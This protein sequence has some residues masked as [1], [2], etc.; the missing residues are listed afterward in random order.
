MNGGGKLAKKISRKHKTFADEYIA[1]GGNGR[2]AY[3]VAYPHI[4]NKHTASTGANRILKQENVK[5]YIQQKTQNVLDTRRKRSEMMIEQLADYVFR[6]D[7]E[8]Y[9]KQV[10]H[11]TGEITTER[12]TTFQPGIE[13]SIRAADTLGKWLG[14]ENVNNDL[15]RKKME[16][17]IELIQKK[18]DEGSIEHNMEINIIDPW[19]DDE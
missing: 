13:E 18:V 17:E 5:R 4:T 16:A 19:T 9:L 15:V 7:Q 10:D 3:Y 12:T 8:S 14:Y 2:N 1:N 11:L 6:E